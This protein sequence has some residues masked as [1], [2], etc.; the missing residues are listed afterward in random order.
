MQRIYVIQ[1]LIWPKLVHISMGG[2]DTNWALFNLLQRNQ[3]ENE[4]P[5]LVNIGSCSLHFLC[6]ALKAEEDASDWNLSKILKLMWK[7]LDD[8]PAQ[9]DTYLGSCNLN[10]IP[11]MF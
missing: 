8:C 6:G 4:Y 7:I 11:M 5:E 1:C 9:R 10:L 3:E 2:L